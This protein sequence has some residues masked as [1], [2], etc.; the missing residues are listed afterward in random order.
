MRR[1]LLLKKETL[2]K[3]VISPVLIDE[4]MLLKEW[5]M[6]WKSTVE[7]TQK[8][9]L[10]VLTEEVWESFLLEKS[11]EEN[12]RE[13]EERVKQV[14]LKREAAL[15]HVK[16]NV[17][18]KNED[19]NV[20]YKI[21]TKEI[22][23]LPANKSLKGKVFDDWYA[24]FYLKMC[25][26]KLD[27]ILSV[28]YVK[29]QEDNDGYKEYKLKDNF[30]KNHLL[31]A[32]IQSNAF[33]FINAKTMS[34]LDMYNKLLDI[35]Q[36]KAHE[37]DRAVI[38]VEEFEKLKFNTNIN[39]GPETFLSK[40]SECLKRMEVDDGNGGTTKQIGDALLPSVFRAKINHP[41]FNTWKLISEKN[42][43]DW[44][45][46]QVSFLRFA[47]QQFTVRHDSSCKY[48]TA[49][50]NKKES[51]ENGEDVSRGEGGG[52]M[53]LTEEYCKK[54]EK[55]CETGGYIA[56]KIYDKLKPQERKKLY[57]AKEVK[58]RNGGLGSQ[59]GVNHQLSNIP[60][61]FALVPIYTT[62]ESEESGNHTSGSLST[63][64]NMRRAANFLQLAN[65]GYVVR[66][67]G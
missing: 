12:E 60:P 56:Q 23:K 65:E 59:Y 38:A 57:D 24:S 18:E 7:S 2:E 44:D 54:F 35:Y 17:S 47:E 13:E 39:Y 52:N 9:L 51:E 64:D 25:Q 1:V 30:L 36:G 5:Y 49:N 28:G 46:V 37:E 48:R 27:D 26:A 34:G 22:P 53:E 21:E 20:S 31:T 62:G 61:G 32:T 15:E 8:E 58:K 19:I 55:A 67:N 66:G 14:Q 4:L 45:S 10:E 43:E 63:N 16:S 29:P 33:S 3:A 41:T 40:V 42:K 11:Q 6:N 50:Q